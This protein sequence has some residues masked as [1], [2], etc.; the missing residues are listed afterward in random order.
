MKVPLPKQQLIILMLLALIRGLI[1]LSLFPPWV[2]PDE[3]A[4]FEVV[5]IMGQEQQSPSFDYYESTSINLELSQSFQTFRMWELLERSTPSPLLAKQPNLVKTSFFDYPYPGHWIL[6]DNYPLLPHAILS[7]IAYLS[8]GFDIATELY[9]LRL[10]SVIL[11]MAVVSLAWLVTKYIFPEQPQFWLA[12][13]AFVTFLP[14]HSHIFASVNTDVFAILLSSGLLLLLVSFFERGFS[15]L[16]ATLVICLV[17]LAFFTKRTVIFTLLWVGLSAILYIGYQRQ[18]SV[19]RITLLSSGL[20]SFISLALVW[21]IFNSQIFINTIFTLF[22]MNIGQNSAAYIFFAGQR[23]P[24]SEFAEIYIKSG[25]FAFITFWG[26]FGGANINIPWPWAWLLMLGCA[27][28]IAAASL[29]LINTLRA[30]ETSLAQRNMLLVLITGLVLSLMNA[31]FPVLAAGVKWG[32]PARYFFPVIIPIATI[33]FLGAWQLC[34]ARYRQTHLLAVWLF[35]LI[36]YDTLV[37]TQV[38][39]PFLYG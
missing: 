21:I 27:L 23:L 30:T 26:D 7:P 9:I 3:P 37:I 11:M 12:I 10:V 32:P 8:S 36:T 35:V 22:N 34:P 33:F 19:K 16:K 15:W 38:L 28:I 20:I 29:Y 17:I 5:R 25:L 14:M 39:L 6:V 1:Y 4:H 13:P 31:F 2:A 18:W 24:L